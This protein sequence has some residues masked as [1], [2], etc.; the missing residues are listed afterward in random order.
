M[1]TR[2]VV[3]RAF[4]V[5]RP[6]SAFLKLY[7]V[8]YHGEQS[9]KSFAP[10]IYTKTGDKGTSSLFTGERRP[11]DDDVFEALGTTDE[12]T[13]AIGL[14]REFCIEKGHIDVVTKLEEIQCILQDVGSSAA[15]PRTSNSPK[16]IS[17]T[18]FITG[19]VEDLE[20]WIDHYQNELPPLKNFILPSGGKASASLHMARS[21][22]RRAERRLIPLLNNGDLEADVVKYVNRL[23]DFLFAAARHAAFSEQKFELIYKRKTKA[24]QKQ[25]LA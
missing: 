13:S 20:S 18:K 8:R 4:N 14:A 16:H 2:T 24:V 25:E 19:N 21:I 23:S 10:K 5:L 7:P 15:T 9:K 12:L 17:R 3:A 22:C 11:K 6:S 1:A